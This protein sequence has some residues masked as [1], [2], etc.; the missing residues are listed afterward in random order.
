MNFYR[1][2]CELC[3]VLKLEW[4]CQEIKGKDSYYTTQ[5]SLAIT[6][7]KWNAKKLPHLFCLTR[8]PAHLIPLMGSAATISLSFHI[9]TNSR[10]SKHNEMQSQTF[11]WVLAVM[12]R[13]T[14]STPA[15]KPEYRCWTQTVSRNCRGVGQHP[16]F[17]PP[18]LIPMLPTTCACNSLMMLTQNNFW[19]ILSYSPYLFL[20]AAVWCTACGA[21]GVSRQQPAV[22]FSSQQ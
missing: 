19:I 7:G 20:P 13:S 2:T 18:S 9:H 1:T 3:I 21:I 4:V 6:N 8:Y 16:M 10:K 22:F 17:T 5:Y 14:I 11:L 15:G 12:M